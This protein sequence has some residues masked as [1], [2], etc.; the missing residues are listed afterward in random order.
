MIV[1]DVSGKVKSEPKFRR[2][3]KEAF[4]GGRC[5]FESAEQAI[6]FLRA[7]GMIKIQLVTAQPLNLTKIRKLLKTL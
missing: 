4:P 5:E 3:I 6:K 7:A 1:L 2:A